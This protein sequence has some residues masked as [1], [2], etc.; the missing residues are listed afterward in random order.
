MSRA[1]KKHLGAAAAAVAALA[2]VTAAPA[3]AVDTSIWAGDSA[4]II[5]DHRVDPSTSTVVFSYSAFV[6]VDD[7]QI[8]HLGATVTFKCWGL[9]RD[10]NKVPTFSRTYDHITTPPLQV[11]GDGILIS[12]SYSAARGTLFNTNRDGY[13]RLGCDVTFS[14]PRYPGQVTKGGSANSIGAF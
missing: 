9:D 2:V 6:T 1:L 8:I 12:D 7:P 10:H 5:N 3:H 4:T 11:Y 13:D 14:D